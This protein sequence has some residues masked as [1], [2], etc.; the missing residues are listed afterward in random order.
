MMTKQEIL[1]SGVLETYVLG[2]CSE[3]ESAS[4]QWMS[5]KDM[6]IKDAILEYHQALEQMAIIHS[7]ELPLGMKEKLKGK[8]E[9]FDRNKAGE[10][11]HGRWKIISIA[12]AVA[13]L[14]SFGGNFY[15]STEIDSVKSALEIAQRQNQK[16]AYETGYLKQ[17]KAE[18]SDQLNLLLT[19]AKRTVVMNGQPFAP[20]AKATIYWKGQEVYLFANTFPSNVEGKQYQLWAIV[21][22]KPVDAGVFDINSSNSQKLIRLKD[23]MNASAFAVT[24]EKKGGSV[25]PTLEK[26]LVLGM[27]E[28]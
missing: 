20:N 11:S 21:D 6:E 9:T 14:V 22:G 16:L 8:L 10:N 4:I 5:M 27:V 19:D 25:T 7:K 3:E 24:E 23:V 13:A 15:L 28:S 2:A 17:E 26:M 1:E 18:T 12:A